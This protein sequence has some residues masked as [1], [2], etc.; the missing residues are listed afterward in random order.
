[1]VMDPNDPLPPGRSR[2]TRIRR[3]ARGRWFNGDEPITH[4]N[5]VQSFDQWLDRAPDGRFCL[6]NDINWAYV[7]VEG[8]PV[9]VRAAHIEGDAV[10]LRLSGDLEERLDPATLRQG[11][12][13]VLYCDVRE[14]RLPARF[15]SHAAAQLAPLLGEDARG[16]YLE[17]AGRRF[18]PPV[19]DDPLTGA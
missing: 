13:G 17:L 4:P 9:F 7:A 15:D 16:I 12:D 1:M 19:R 3:D 18:E 2:E 11:P 6:S 5:L 10:V 8:A 14:G